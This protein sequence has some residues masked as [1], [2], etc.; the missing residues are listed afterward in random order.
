VRVVIA[1]DEVL[2]R[3]GLARLLEDAGVEVVGRCGD[4]DAL[5]R[6]VDARRPDVAL[7]DIRMPPHRGD[8]L[9]AAREIR[10]HHPEIGVLVLSHHLES[11]DA[12]RLLEDVP[13]RAG[14]L[15]KERVSDLAVLTDAPHRI[16]E[17]ECVVDPTIVSRLVPASANAARSTSRPTANATSSRRSPR[18]TPTARSPNGC[19]S[20]AR[21]SRRTSPR[22]CSSSIWPTRPSATG[23]SS[24]CS[25]GCDRAKS[26]QN[27]PDAL[28]CAE[29]RSAPSN[30]AYDVVERL[31][32]GS[33]A[34]LGRPRCRSSSRRRRPRVRGPSRARR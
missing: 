11:R 20:H 34:G 3:D 16:D 28:A 26:I 27:R 29:I 33:S 14:H 23:A 2:L 31:R 13:E 30:R 5:L 12:M 32:S 9:H 17:G 7:V 24:P 4:A 21:P 22:S 1:D 15:L 6:T 18:V 10:R 19:T 8:G 25:P